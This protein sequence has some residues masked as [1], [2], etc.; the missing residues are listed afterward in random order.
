VRL[1]HSTPAFDV[2]LEHGF[3]DRSY[4]DSRGSSST[5]SGVWFSDRALGMTFEFEAA[6][7]SLG[8]RVLVVDLPAEI[9]SRYEVFEA[10]PGEEDKAF[11]EFLIPAE[12]VNGYRP[13]EIVR[14]T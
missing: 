14:P 8:T 9:A 11:R 5:T 3:E 13:L 7:L 2:I 1:Y 4:V 6:E 12:L 10:Y